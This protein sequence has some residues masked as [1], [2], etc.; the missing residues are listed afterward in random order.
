ME[1][2]CSSQWQ[3]ASVPPNTSK[4]ASH[5][6]YKPYT[7]HWMGKGGKKRSIYADLFQWNSE[8]QWLGWTSRCWRKTWCSWKSTASGSLRYVT[9]LGE[10]ETTPWMGWTDMVGTEND[11]MMLPSQRSLSRNQNWKENGPG[12]LVKSYYMNQS[13][14]SLEYPARS[15]WC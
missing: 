15:L 7:L 12:S 6:P 10:I 1:A 9:E 8:I 13:C 3:A 4:H 5:A 2:P 14:P 11:K